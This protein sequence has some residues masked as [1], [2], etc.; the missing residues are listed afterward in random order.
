MVTSET[1]YLCLSV[2]SD[3]CECPDA[4]LLK[5]LDD[6][7]HCYSW[8]TLRYGLTI[9]P[10]GLPPPLTTLTG[11]GGRYPSGFT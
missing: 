11:N 7:P 3:D 6:K 10:P 9:S 8:P 5:A 2:Q 1:I 4:M